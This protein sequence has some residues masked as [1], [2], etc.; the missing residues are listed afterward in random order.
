MPGSSLLVPVKTA[1]GSVH[2]DRIE[3]QL[4]RFAGAKTVEQVTIPAKIYRVKKKDTLQKIAKRFGLSV[5]TL[6]RLNKLEGEVRAGMRLVIRPAQR[7]I[8]TQQA[9]N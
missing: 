4:A 1:D 7:K 6:R 2:V 5:A 9:A 8:V 3:S